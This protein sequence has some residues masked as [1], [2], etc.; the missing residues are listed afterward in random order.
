MKRDYCRTNYQRCM[1]KAGRR[2][3]WGLACHS[4]GTRIEPTFKDN[5]SAGAGQRDQQQC[6]PYL[7]CQVTT[8]NP[9]QLSHPLHLEAFHK[10]AYSTPSV[11]LVATMLTEGVH[12]TKPVSI[13]VY[14][15][16]DLLQKK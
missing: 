13:A 9:L 11:S 16:H 10:I 14:N 8:R 4:I 6:M 1:S 2:C 5:P 7:T 12:G 3:M 15:P